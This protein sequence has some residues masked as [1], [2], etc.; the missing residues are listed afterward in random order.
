MTGFQ[1]LHT[2]TTFCDGTRLPQDMIEAAIRKGCDS[3]G[4]SDHSY[5]TFDKDYAMDPDT[6]Q[7]YICVINALK[8]EYDGAI[9]IFLGIEQD[10]HTAWLP[11]GL[12][13]RIGAAH[14]I[15]VGDE[16]VSVDSGAEYQQRMVDTYF[17]GDHY[18]MAEAYF[19]TIAG[20]M[21]VTDADFI[22]HFDLIA[23]YNFDGCLFDENHPRYI[24]AALGAMDEILKRCK[25]FEVNT[26]MMFRFDKPEPYPSVFLL[27]ELQKRGG[28]VI[29]SSDSHV[30]E[31]LCHKFGE[32][33][34]LL[35]V[36]GFK[37]IKRLT[38]AG[39][40]DTPI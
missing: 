22:G 27:K 19:S 20:I 24:S 29:L 37:H 39:F 26:G 40:V 28:E 8:A 31:G 3:I 14:Y 25:L 2:H 36:C 6:T 38:N 12:D 21:D 16:Y 35:G 9:E 11:E 15:R 23:K 33:R 7:E 34:Q 18:A 10:Y 17:S 4:I 30:A 5:V 32:M 1:D 13:Y